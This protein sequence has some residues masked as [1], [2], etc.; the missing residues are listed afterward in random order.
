MAVEAAD[1]DLLHFAVDFDRGIFHRQ[2]SVAAVAFGTD[3]SD[4]GEGH[5]C[6]SYPDFT[7]GG[8]F[9]RVLAAGACLFG[10]AVKLNGDFVI[11]HL[12][13]VVVHQIA[14]HQHGLSF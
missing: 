5:M 4:A 3:V 11:K 12:Q 14:L 9:E 6:A 10:V 8:I 2:P 1:G 7:C 13:C